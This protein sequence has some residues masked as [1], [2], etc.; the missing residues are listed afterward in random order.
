M[1]KW[2]RSNRRI[3][4]DIEEQLLLNSLTLGGI[5]AAIDNLNQSVVD[6][7][8]QVVAVQAAIAALKSV[9]NNDA[10]IQSAADSINTAITTLG[11]AIK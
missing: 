3:L 8:A 1:I 7:N 2:C 6:L 11:D 5:M 9:P 4:I 10:A